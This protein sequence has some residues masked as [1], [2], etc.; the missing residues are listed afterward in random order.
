MGPLRASLDVR[1]GI[2]KQQNG[3]H[4]SVF[5]AD[6]VRPKNEAFQMTRREIKINLKDEYKV[7][8]KQVDM[9]DNFKQLKF[10]CDH[11]FFKSIIRPRL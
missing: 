3:R 2:S 8:L 5:Q 10:K 9:L 6:E 4:Y 11:C 7:H 1:N